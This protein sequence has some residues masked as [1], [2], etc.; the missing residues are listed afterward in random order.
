MFPSFLRSYFLSRS[1]TREA[2][3]L[4]YVLSGTNLYEVYPF[5]SRVLKLLEVYI[6]TVFIVTLL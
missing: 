5:N 3:P 2:A 4:C 6:C 1:T